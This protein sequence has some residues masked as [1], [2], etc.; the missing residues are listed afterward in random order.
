MRAFLD[1]HLFSFMMLFSSFSLS[2]S[3][4]SSCE[5]QAQFN[6]NRW[7]KTGDV[8]LGGLFLSHLASVFPEQSFTSREQDPTCYV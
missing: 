3:S 2:S 1:I 5:L 4:S 8:V 7:Y 6:L